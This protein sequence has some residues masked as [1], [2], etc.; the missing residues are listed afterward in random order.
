[1]PY[2]VA[3]PEEVIAAASAVTLLDDE[4]FTLRVSG[5]FTLAPGAG[6]KVLRLLDDHP[7]LARMLATGISTL[8]VK[9]SLIEVSPSAWAQMRRGLTLCA[10]EASDGELRVEHGEAWVLTFPASSEPTRGTLK[11]TSRLPTA[12]HTRPEP[13]RR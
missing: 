6:P 2:A 11:T 1:M 9:R 10:S 12:K 5:E 3:I 7:V 13:R 4:L 8:Y